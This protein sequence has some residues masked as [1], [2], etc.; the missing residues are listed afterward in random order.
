MILAGIK[1]VRIAVGY[2]F[3]FFSFT[4]NLFNREVGC[5]V[6]IVNGYIQSCKVEVRIEPP[7]TPFKQIAKGFV[8][9]I[10]YAKDFIT[11]HSA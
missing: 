4:L 10:Q 7:F 11:T 8:V 1:T 2:V 3:L 6:L 5:F 9:H